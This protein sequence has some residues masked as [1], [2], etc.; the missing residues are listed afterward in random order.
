MKPTHLPLTIPKRRF[1]VRGYVFV[2]LFLVLAGF[3]GWVIIDDIR[4]H[5]ATVQ[6]DIPTDF[7]NA[8][9]RQAAEGR[10]E[11]VRDTSWLSEYQVAAD[12]PRLIMAPSIGLKARILEMGI[13]PDGSMQAPINVFD[14]GWYTG[15]AKPGEEGAM[16]IDGHAS[17]P[18]REGLFAYIDTLEPGTAIT[19][20]RGDGTLVQYKV[21]HVES[22][23]LEDVDMQQL[24]R[25]Y[26]DATAG[27]NLITC[28]GEWLAGQQTYNRRVIVYAQLAG[29]GTY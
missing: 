2:I 13:N 5:S 22:V 1:G 11:S 4:T 9:Q 27:L 12:A 3:G 15:S 18:T 25:P 29:G 24:L 16:V 6:P 17:G 14:S 28:A 8:E 10:D 7:E 20:E 23:P 19:V 21:A 26:G